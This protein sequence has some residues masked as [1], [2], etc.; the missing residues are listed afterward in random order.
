MG[1][2]AVHGIFSGDTIIHK[3]YWGSFE[4]F[5]GFCEIFIE[6]GKP[7]DEYFWFLISKG[8]KTYKMLPLFFKEFYPSYKKPTPIYEK[9]IIDA[10]GKE[11]YPDEYNEKSGNVEYNKTKD[12]LKK[13]VANIDEKHSKDKHI[14]FFANKNPGH[15]DGNDIVCL[16]SLKEDNIRKTAYRLFI[17]GE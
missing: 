4:L 5:K 3:D 16:T 9:S 11:R 12:R 14:E 1:G 10:F 7:F 8:Y 13:G 6:Y 15:I 17:E 2:K